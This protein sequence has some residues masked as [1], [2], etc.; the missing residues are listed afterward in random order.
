MLLQQTVDLEPIGTTTI[1]RA[2][3][4]HAHVVALA[5]ATRLAGGAILFVDDAFALVLALTDGADVVVRATKEG[6]RKREGEERKRR[7]AK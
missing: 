2:A 4:G 3:L 5:Q 6:L 1:A 7:L